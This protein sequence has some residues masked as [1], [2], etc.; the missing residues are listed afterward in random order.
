MRLPS[1]GDLSPDHDLA[2]GTLRG[3]PF[4]LLRVVVLAVLRGL[5]GLRVEGAEH[6]P[7]TGPLLVVF[8]HLHNAD[9]I[10]LSAAFPRPMHF[11]AKKVLFGI[12]VVNRII[13]RVGA[14]PVDRG[15]ADRSAIRR[16]EATLAQGIPVAMFPEGTRS[17]S[18]AL[19]PAQPGAA[20]LALRAGVPV[21]PV[22]ITGSEFFPGNG[23]K[24][25]PRQ[26]PS[27]RAMRRV[28]VQI[29]QPFTLPREIDGRRITNEE[30]A[31][32]MMRELAS[33][34]PP[35]YRGAYA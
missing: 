17:R 32:R 31:E 10:I 15:K 35:Q 13:R 22:A 12:P 14:F 8:N 2:R 1:L 9:P 27:L 11:M 34:L 26:R 18:R 29:G 21:V 4:R 33:L 5:I 19:Q 16:A 25:G 30:A 28:R 6:V 23:R 24:S 7:P 20:L 3:R